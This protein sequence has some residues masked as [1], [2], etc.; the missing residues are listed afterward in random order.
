MGISARIFDLIFRHFKYRNDPKSSVK[1]SDLDIRSILTNELLSF[2]QSA[3]LIFNLL[4]LLSF[5]LCWLPSTAN[6]DK[7]IGLLAGAGGLGD[8]S[9]NDM[10][11]AGLG[12]AQKEYHFKLIVEET[13]NSFDSQEAGLKKLI[14]KGANVIVANGSGLEK[15]VMKYSPLYPEKYFLVNDSV[16]ENHSN[17]TTT[18]FAHKEGSYLAG[19]LAASITKTGS[20]GFIGGVDLPII[21]TFLDGYEQG[22]KRVSDTIVIKNTFISPAGDFSGFNNPALGLN[23]ATEMYKN[24][25]DIIFSVAGLTGNGIIQ[26][27]QRQDKLVIG[28]DANQDHMAKGNVLTSMMKRLDRA[29]Y[30]EIVKILEG[31]FES[32]VKYYGLSNGGVSLTPMSYTRHLVP[33]SVKDLLKQT[34][35]DIINGKI[36]I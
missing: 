24:G 16:I 21:R 10:T 12:K 28:V 2:R 36:K 9:Y 23:V 8:Q 13:Q 1:T 6:A 14:Q 27:A 18:A 11:F 31:T 33:D 3:F 25:V 32:G 19:M 34:E 4:L 26:A 17:V 20:I 29:T 22:A 5:L 15:L 30:A 35:R 7:I